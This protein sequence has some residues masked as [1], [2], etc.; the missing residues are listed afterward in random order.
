MPNDFS[1]RGGVCVSEC[2][3]GT[4]HKL[5]KGL[6]EGRGKSGKIPSITLALHFA[7][8]VASEVGL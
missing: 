4:I 6:Q 2:V 7:S 8:E 3:L 1:C 5:R